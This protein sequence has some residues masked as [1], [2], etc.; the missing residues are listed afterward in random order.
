MGKKLAVEVK[1]SNRIT[2]RDLRGLKALSEEACF[3]KRIVVCMEENTRITED[4]IIIQHW[5]SF[6]KELWNPR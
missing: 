1:A 3:E 5:S 6:L 2:S 4:G